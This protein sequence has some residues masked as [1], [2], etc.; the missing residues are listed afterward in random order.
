MG[1]DPELAPHVEAPHHVGVGA[2]VRR[3]VGD[4]AVVLAVE[5]ALDVEGHQLAAIG[6]VVEAIAFDGRGR[7][8]SLQREVEGLFELGV[9]RLPEERAVGGAKRHQH[10]AI[11][12]DR[13]VARLR[14]VGADEDLAAGHHRTAVGVGPQLGDPADVLAGARIP[15]QRQR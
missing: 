12:G 14:V 7:A 15:A 11:V 4:R 5:E 2:T 1:H 10:A 9:G 6:D 3:L 8:H 13:G